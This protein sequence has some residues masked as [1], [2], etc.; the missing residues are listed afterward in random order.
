MIQRKIKWII[1]ALL[2]MIKLHM[3]IYIFNMLMCDYDRFRQAVIYTI[4]IGLI[5]VG[6]LSFKTYKEVKNGVL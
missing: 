3:I 4:I 5:V 2:S 6:E 1:I